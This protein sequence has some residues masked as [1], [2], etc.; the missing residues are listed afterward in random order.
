MNSSSAP[1]RA[2]TAALAAI[3]LWSSLATLTVNLA[4]VPALLL[5]GLTLTIGGLAGLP[6]LSLRGLRPHLM[7]LG[8]YG[9]FTYHLC[10]FLAF[11]YAPPVAANL[12]NY[13]WPLLIVLLSPVILPGVA[14][15]PRHWVAGF[16]GFAGAGLLVTGGRLDTFASEAASAQFLGY[17]LAIAAA[18]IWASYSLLTQRVA[19]FPTSSVSAFCL[20]SGALA[21]AS[22]A[23]LEPTYSLNGAE[24]AQVLALGLG[25]MGA[26]FYLWDYA[27]KQGDSRVIGSLA[28]LTPLLST[29]WLALFAGGQLT[30]AAWMA[31]GLIIGG[32]LIGSRRG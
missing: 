19:R 6:K 5:V 29:L 12:L 24:W 2:Y 7:L 9:L 22:H 27:M 13:L 28:Y 30:S 17:G 1:S 15:S 23:L 26:S 20:A 16:M 25:P 11:R 3:V 8:V 18:F 21:L 4:Q 32:A 31:M 10:L 14:L